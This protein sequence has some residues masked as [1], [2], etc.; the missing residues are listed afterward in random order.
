MY[1]HQMTFKTV[2]LNPANFVTNTWHCLA[3]D[4]TAGTDFNGGVR[5][6]YNS[7]TTY[8]S[9]LLAQNGHEVKIYDLED[10]EPRAPI[11]EFEWNLTSAPSGSALPPEVALCL[12]FQAEKLSGQTQARRRNRLYI[13]PLDTTACGS[14]GRPAPAF[15]T[16]M[17]DAGQAVF[18]DAVGEDYDWAIF[19]TFAPT[20]GV[21]AANG[22]VDNEF[23]TQRRRGRV[24]TAR[25][26]F[27][28]P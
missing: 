6:F 11:L 1:R 28:R 23:D 19:S 24:S 18:D 2:D 27:T 4:A 13:G 20:T 21:I 22:W 10:P 25:E 14:D 9:P 26:I 8:L 5:A 15:V 7:L 16:A 12:S 3:P 17:A